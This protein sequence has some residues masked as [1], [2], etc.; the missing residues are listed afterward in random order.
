[1]YYHSKVIQ[2]LNLA[3]YLN[4]LTHG[5]MRRKMR[6]TRNENISE[7]WILLRVLFIYALNA[8]SIFPTGRKSPRLM[9]EFPLAIAHLPM[10]SNCAPATANQQ[11]PPMWPGHTRHPIAQHYDQQ[12]GA[13]EK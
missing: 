11:P 4:W 2:G 12:E 5:H 7:A 10:P 6:N 9:Y 1:M 13:S 8:Q 3:C